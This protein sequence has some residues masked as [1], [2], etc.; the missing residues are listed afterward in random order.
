[1]KDKFTVRRE[2][3]TVEFACSNYQRIASF[4]PPDH[5]DQV[6]RVKP[7][8]TE[9]LNDIM[10]ILPLATDTINLR[11]YDSEPVYNANYLTSQVQKK[12]IIKK[13]VEVY[14]VSVR[15][16]RQDKLESLGV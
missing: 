14:Y 13:Q 6:I 8:W 9:G 11:W 7:L 5:Y 16:D 10:V 12:G 1:M 4:L 3:I 15:M 2:V